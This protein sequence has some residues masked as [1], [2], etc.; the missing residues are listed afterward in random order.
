MKL[1][2][3]DLS[4]ETAIIAEVGVNHEGNVDAALKMVALAAEAGADAVKFQ[5]YTP[6][7]FI[8]SDDDARFERVT[9]F[10]L[11]EADH[12]RL[13]EEANKCGIAFFSTAV[14]EDWVPFIA[15]HCEAVK[16]ASG[17]LDFKPVISAAAKSGKTVILS[18][19]LGEIEEIDAAVSWVRDAIGDAALED[20]LIL[21]QCVSAYP[22]PVE[23]ANVASVQFLADRYGITTGY[24]NHV[25]GLDACLAAAALGAAVI[26]VHFTDQREGKTF[27]D[28]ALSAE[29]Q[30]LA[31]LVQMVP[32]IRAAVGQAGKSRQPSETRILDAVRKGLV[33]ARD[34]A[35]GEVI[36][37]EDLM[38]ARPA[39]EF[40]SH[41]L[42]SVVGRKLNS[43]RAKGATIRR[44][45]IS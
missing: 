21:M 1:F 24:S 33:A 18:T 11:S 6:D 17:D 44:E 13:K 7:R 9:R 12:L 31:Q 28:H 39:T 32:N 45:D 37:A 23:E 14:T 34:L 10:G 19:G 43:A 16:I 30:E 20:R 2:G 40:T 35:K 38:Y 25:K 3:K 36:A 15:S 8:S 29:P 42:A 27:H 41:D 5:S 22:T 4:S 26:E